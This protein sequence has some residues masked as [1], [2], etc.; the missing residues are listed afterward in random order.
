MLLCLI[1]N[2]DLQSMEQDNA[3]VLYNPTN[4]ENT[5]QEIFNEI[6]IST[7]EITKE[8]RAWLENT[9]TVSKAAKK[10]IEA[11]VLHIN[12]IDS[13]KRIMRQGVKPEKG[14]YSVA[15]EII[16]CNTNYLDA[17][18][19][20]I[21]YADL[22]N[23]TYLLPTFS[24]FKAA[25]QLDDKGQEF[26]CLLNAI[27]FEAPLF[28]EIYSL[29][30]QAKNPS[31][32]HE[33]CVQS[34][35]KCFAYQMKLDGLSEEEALKRTGELYRNVHTSESP[36]EEE[37]KSLA[38]DVLLPNMPEITAAMR[39]TAHI[40]ADGIRTIVEKYAYS[41]LHNYP[42]LSKEILHPVLISIAQN[43]YASYKNN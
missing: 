34:L 31:L 4:L 17:L 10:S 1:S 3:L 24:H 22:R 20:K 28:K 23:N 13:M 25:Y 38:I 14:I 29:I 9:K 11:Y 19:K 7:T 32:S 18:T 36:E 30:A 35:A 2:V 21:G 5:P 42:H 27:P 43:I 40:N 6:V 39:Q 8:N 16:V 41:S 37:I 26:G 15:D 12:N 33:D